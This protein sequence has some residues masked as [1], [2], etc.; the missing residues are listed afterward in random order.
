MLIN[1]RLVK[2]LLLVF[3]VVSAI[4]FAYSMS[5]VAEDQGLSVSHNS[6]VLTVYKR[7]TCKC[8][9]KWVRHAERS[10]FQVETINRRDLSDLKIDRGIQ[11]RYQSCHTA[12]S[13]NGYVFEG[14]IP[15]KFIQQFLQEKPK[16]AIGLSVPAMP[17]GTPGMEYRNKFMPYQVLLLKAD[18]SAETYARINS[19]E[20]Q[21]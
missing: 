14:H 5:V 4:V 19:Q 17:V 1:Q 21:Y 18:G 11:Q 20:E 6:P 10:G 7:P 15:A 12:I 13:K 8:C 2:R 16:D 9:G 3:M